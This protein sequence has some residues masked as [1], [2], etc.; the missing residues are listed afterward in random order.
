MNRL[1]YACFYAVTALILTKDLSSAKHSGV[2]M[3][4][5]QNFVKPGIIK[6][7]LGQ[8]YDKLFRNRLKGDYTDYLRFSKDEIAPW[9]DESQNFVNVL[10]ELI[11][12]EINDQ[13]S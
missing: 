5:H 10:T 12:K 11:K 3:L 8:F 7:E 6:I 9:Q 2:R 4:F 1:Y 13:L